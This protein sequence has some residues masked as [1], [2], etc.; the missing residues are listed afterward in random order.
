MKTL[1]IVVPVYFNEQS[2]APLFERIQELETKLLAR[3][4]QL[5]LIFV[6][7]GS[8]DDSLQEL[9]KIKEQRPLTKIVKLTRNFGAV[10]ASKTGFKYVTGD[11][12]VVLAA[13]LQDP[14]ELVLEMTDHWLNGCKFVIC[15]RKKRQDPWRKVFFAK[16]YYKLLKLCVDKKFPHG[17]YDLALMDKAILPLLQ[18]SSKN[19]YTPVFCHWLGFK[20]KIIYYERQ[21]REFGKSRWSFAKRVKAF[22]DAILGFSIV[23]IRLISFI[24]FIISLISFGYGGLV[25]VNALLGKSILPG[26]PTLV[27][28]ISFLCGLIIIMLGVIGEYLW[29]IFE[30][31]NKRPETV[32]DEVY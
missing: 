4:I 7:D 14:P 31:V 5:E 24:G 29:R 27:A 15:V 1:S 22:L 13:D 6:D 18:N 2:L 9:F 20:P 17:G 12:F 30:E 10:H 25:A 3:S 26:F 21:K 32:I 8:G 19:I 28:L 16:V 23:P 11:C